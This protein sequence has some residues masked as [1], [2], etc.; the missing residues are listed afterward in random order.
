MIPRF[1]TKTIIDSVKH[2]PITL[3]TG[4][5][6]IGKTTELLNSLTPKV[7]IIFHLMTHLTWLLQEKTLEASWIFILLH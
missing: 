2:F 4:P 1:I 3:L 5:R 6:Q 7:L